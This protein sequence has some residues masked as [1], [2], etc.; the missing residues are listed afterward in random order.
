M[1]P[2]LGLAFLIGSPAI[3]WVANHSPRCRR[4]PVLILFQA[5]ELASEPPK[6]AVPGFEVTEKEVSPAPIVRE[7]V[8]GASQLSTFREAEVLGLRL[9]QEGKFDDALQG[10]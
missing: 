1:K 7:P 9:M 5:D 6:G 8:N 3:A 4:R 2:T 10:N